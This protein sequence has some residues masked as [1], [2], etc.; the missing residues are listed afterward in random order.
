MIALAV[1][2]KDAKAIASAKLIAL[3]GEKCEWLRSVIYRAVS[4]KNMPPDAHSSKLIDVDSLITDLKKEWGRKKSNSPDKTQDMERHKIT[5]GNETQKLEQKPQLEN[6]EIGKKKDSSPKKACNNFNDHVIAEVKQNVVSSEIQ[7]VA[8]DPKEQIR[9]IL[10]S[11]TKTDS[12]ALEKIHVKVA[13]ASVDSN[14]H[15]YSDHKLKDDTIPAQPE[16][17]KTTSSYSNPNHPKAPPRNGLSTSDPTNPNSYNL[18]PPSSPPKT[19]KSQALESPIA[20]HFDNI[21]DF[22]MSVLAFAANKDLPVS[23]TVSQKKGIHSVCID[24]GNLGCKGSA[25][26]TANVAIDN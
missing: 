25:V 19:R 1:N 21:N 6:Q 4:N 3:L 7:K 16:P 5:P 10:T 8:L 9:R 23:E 15:N 18:K 2:K 13:E 17:Q 24:F 12:S 11:T 14:P 22:F 20:D 26:G